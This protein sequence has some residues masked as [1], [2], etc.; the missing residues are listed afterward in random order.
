MSAPGTRTQAEADAFGHGERR[1][2]TL[3][4]YL[5][6][7][8]ALVGL[9]ALNLCVG[10][11]KVPLADLARILSGADRTSTAARVV[12]DIRMPRLVAASIL[13]SALALAGLLLQTF[14]NN[15][16]AGPYVLGVS[17]GAKLAVAAVMVLVLGSRG[18][19]TSWMLVLAA[20]AGS[21]AA[22]GF[23]LFVSRRIGSQ[24]M[25]IVAGV[26]V[27]YLCGA[28]TDFVI[29]FADDASIVNLRNW[30]QG[31]FSGIGWH[32]VAVM[33]AV[34]L[35]ASASAFLLSKPMAAYQLGEAYA[36]SAGVDVRAFR[37]ALVLLSSLLAACVTAFAG[38]I[39]FVGIA[40]PH[41]VRRLLAS[42]R[43]LVVVPAA[44]LGGAVACLFCDL[45]AR[46]AFAPTEVSVSAVTA[47][48]GAPV[49]IAMLVRRQGR[50]G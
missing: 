2:R 48:F 46:S 13:G 12:W 44:C 17:S 27:G 15:P 42:S 32:D 16:I 21:M 45:V 28:M 26:M 33:A 23:V 40:V 14:F 43:P 29:A 10:S 6:L 11:L 47:L 3:L 7:A 18:V 35:P 41:I 22:M 9:L 39:S 34:T 19:M 38:P 4:V 8:A 20:F 37:T 30:S 1:R 31:S 49:V 25:L 5:L 50:A 36:Q 24:G